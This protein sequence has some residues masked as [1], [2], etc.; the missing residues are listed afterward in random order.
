MS[1]TT[2]G[3]HRLTQPGTD[4]SWDCTGSAENGQVTLFLRQ[5]LIWFEILFR[6]SGGDFLGIARSIVR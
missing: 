1:I 5:S 3:G 6:P 4:Q 2:R